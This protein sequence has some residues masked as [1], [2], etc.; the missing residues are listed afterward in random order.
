MSTLPFIILCIGIIFFGIFVGIVL[1]IFTR[2]QKENMP[3]SF[4][5]SN[6]IYGKFLD[7]DEISIDEVIKDFNL[8]D[9]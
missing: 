1:A 7:Q 8:L 6:F 5:E 9:I 2:K 3:K 4:C